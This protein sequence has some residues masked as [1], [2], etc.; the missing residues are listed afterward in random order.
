MMGINFKESIVVA[1]VATALYQNET[2]S[3]KEI[4]LFLTACLL[5]KHFLLSEV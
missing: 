2:L 4:F 3:A 1:A 5:A